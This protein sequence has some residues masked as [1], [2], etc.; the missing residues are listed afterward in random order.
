M[1][2]AIFGYGL[3]VGEAMLGRGGGGEALHQY[4]CAVKVVHTLKY[5]NIFYA[6]LRGV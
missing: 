1:N 2:M 5:S 4:S 6:L 3:M